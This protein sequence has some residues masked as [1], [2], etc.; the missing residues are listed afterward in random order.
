MRTTHCQRP[1]IDCARWNVRSFRDDLLADFFVDSWNAD[2]DRWLHLRERL[3]QLGKVRTIRK[4]DS[5]I[6]QREVHVPSRHVR[7]R[8][9]RNTDLMLVPKAKGFH[10]TSNVRGHVAVCEHR[11]LR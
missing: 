5:A 11:S 3:S 7:E 10:R 6:E 8:E 1:A 2:K 4:R 9:K